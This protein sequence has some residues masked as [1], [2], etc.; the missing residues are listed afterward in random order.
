MPE[1]YFPLKVLVCQNCW[2][3]QTEDFVDPDI[4]FSSDYAYFSNFSQTWKQHCENYYESVT[5][6]FNLNS[7]SQF[8][9]I[10]SND[11]CLLNYFHSNGIPSTGIEPTASTAAAS[12]ML[13]HDVVEEFFSTELAKIMVKKGKSA[14]LIAANNVLAH[15]PN[16]KDFIGAFAILLKDTGVVTFEFPYLLNLIKFNQ[17]DT[18]YHEH[19][20]YLSLTVVKSIL[21]SSGLSIF[22]VDELETHGGSL[23][24]YA[25]HEATGIQN[26]TSKVA[27]LLSLEE[28]A[29]IADINF[30]SGFQK[31]TNIVKN[32]FLEFLIGAYN[33]NKVVVAY[34]AAA[35]GNTLLNYA[36]IKPDLLKYVVDRNPYKQNKFMPGSHIPIVNEG[37]LLEN[38]PDY[39]VILPWNIRSEIVSQLNYV[40]NW[41][42]KFVTAIPKLEIF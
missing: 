1:Y 14:D 25:Q 27:E 11:G 10:A 35:K 23:R 9:E 20:S 38:K 26:T 21:N 37:H 12:R 2:L 32:D 24:V 18:I 29:G 4:M 41:G 19:F 17:F 39:I 16:I 22:D 13:N 6:R 36:G 28:S 33:D 15:V 5:N 40:K 8:V 3:V 34:G 31:K 7:E 30:Y 42:C